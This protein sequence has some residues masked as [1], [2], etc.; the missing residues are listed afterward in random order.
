MR[1]RLIPIYSLLAVAIVLLAVLVPSCGGTTGTIEVKATLCGNPWQ[2]AVNYTLT[3][4]GGSPTSG[5]AVPTTHSSL[6]PGT[7]TCAY[8]AGGPI[9]AF[10][11]S[12]RPS[13][14]QS[15]VAGGTITFTLDF[16]LNQDAAIEFLNWTVD[17]IPVPPEQPINVEV[18]PCQVIDVH[19]QQWVNGCPQRVVGANETSRLWVAYTPLEG[20]PV[21]I[22]A[23]N[24]WCALNK[25]PEPPDKVSQV[26]S[27]NGTPVVKGANVTLN[28]QNNVILDA[29]TAW[30]LAKETNYTKS[31][32]WLGISTVAMFEENGPHP[33]VLFELVVPGPGVYVFTLIAS[34]EVELVDDEDVNMDNNEATSPPVGLVVHVV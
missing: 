27:F 3:P 25:T 9:G 7:W 14:S 28:P 30:Q 19:F 34:A 24:D 16:E 32:N 8:V 23:V 5:T 18:V 15:L 10:L 12:T 13:A 4:T 22:Y 33:C 11:N 31:I 6:D 17:G 2:G 29:E 26:P 20:P 21:T 1:K